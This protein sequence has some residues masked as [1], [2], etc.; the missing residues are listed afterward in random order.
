MDPSRFADMESVR[1]KM[2]AEF[3]LFLECARYT[4]SDPAFFTLLAN[5]FNQKRK[6][7]LR[8]YFVDLMARYI[9]ALGHPLRLSE[10][11]SI[12]LNFTSEVLMTVFYY[13]NQILDKKSGVDTYEAVCK[14]LIQ[15]NLLLSELLFYVDWRLKDSDIKWHVSLLIRDIYAVVNIGQDVENRSN[16]YANWEK[17]DFDIPA[18][19]LPIDTQIIDEICQLLIELGIKNENLPAFRCYLT[20][21]YLTNAY[22]FIEYTKFLSKCAQ[23]PEKEAKKLF[24]Y[25]AF[26]GIMFQMVNDVCDLVPSNINDGTKAKSSNDAFA[27]IKRGILTVPVILTLIRKPAGRLKQ[28]LSKEQRI[29]TVYDELDLL[30]EMLELGVVELSKLIA[31]KINDLSLRNLYSNNSLYLFLEDV[32]KISTGNKNYN[33]LLKVEND[34]KQ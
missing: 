4:P 25:A 28:V 24:N 14:N 8:A 31:L 20:R 10:T 5:R 7:V 2:Q 11:E 12:V 33:K 3:L 13:D 9:E 17:N 29:T 19:N 6:P 32:N 22:L 16:L 21:V 34:L 15:S 26:T 1:I 23:L 30:R 27:D 18:Y